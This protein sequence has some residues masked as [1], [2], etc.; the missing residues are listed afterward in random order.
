MVSMAVAAEMRPPED[1]A[2]SMV[3]TLIN[4]FPDAGTEERPVPQLMG[5]SYKL[6]VGTLCTDNAGAGER[7]N[8]EFGGSQCC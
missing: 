4:D 5:P 8:W 3:A 2:A 6:A 7:C 1:S